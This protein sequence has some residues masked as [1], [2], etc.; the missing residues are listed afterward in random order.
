MTVI[1]LPCRTRFLHIPLL[2]SALVRVKLAIRG[3]AFEETP[4]ELGFLH[5]IE[6]MLASFTSKKFPSNEENRQTLARL[7]VNSNASTNTH[8]VD[9]YMEA[10]THH[11]TIL[12]EY[13]ME[14][15]IRP[16]FEWSMFE[17]EKNVVAQEYTIAMADG[18]A[19]LGE[20][21]DSTFFAG[22][23]LA[24]SPSETRAHLT[25]CTHKSL[26][27]THKKFFRRENMTIIVSG[28]DGESALKQV[29][30]MLTGCHGHP[31]TI[32]PP[33]SHTPLQ[34]RGIVY[35]P[36]DAGDAYMLRMVFEVPLTYFNKEGYALTVVDSLLT[37]GLTSHLYRILRDQLG[38]A[39][40]VAGRL[41]LDERFP[42]LSMYTIGVETT[43]ERAR[44]VAEVLLA[45][46]DTV[47]FSKGEINQFREQMR[48]TYALEDMMKTPE[49]LESNYFE[50]VVWM[51]RLETDTQKRQRLLSVT[52]EQAQ[53]SVRWLMSQNKTL[54]YSGRAHVI[55]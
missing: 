32:R 36:N 47:I 17:R 14:M 43:E 4:E 26:L 1:T 37:V 30:T 38:A 18:W 11:Q 48:T 16:S 25:T 20:T 39:Y 23:V 5:V 55:V 22:T 49:Y 9:F 42:T 15:I 45:T 27:A 12:L 46:L 28:G 24:S 19:S 6:H 34:D 13:L 54:F 33:I 53:G 51:K 7:G 50:E 35:V 2:Q 52:L 10:L 41:D 3:G 44:E 40:G 31:S 29:K 21:I 8:Y